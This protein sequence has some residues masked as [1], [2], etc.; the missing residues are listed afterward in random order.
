MKRRTRTLLA[1][2]L[3]LAAVAGNA[4]TLLVVRKTDNAVDFIDP[5]S[6][7]RLDT[8]PLGLAPHEISVSPD[9][10]Y[11]AVSNYGTRESPGSTVSVLD[12]ER[13]LELRRIDLSP[14]TR[15]H[16]LA[17]FAP[18]R[19][20]VTTEGSRAL[21]IVDPLGGQTVQ[22]IDTGQDISHMVAVTPDGSTA[23]VANIGSGSTTAIDLRTGKRLAQLATGKGSEGLAV[24]A[25]GRELWVGA[26]AEGQLAII[27]IRSLEIVARLAVPGLPIRI[28]ATPDGDTVLVTCAGFSE[29][30]AYDAASR[31]ERARRPIDVPLAPGADERPFARLAPGSALPVGLILSSSGRSVFVAATMADKVIELDLPLLEAR[32]VIDV[33]G[34][35][36]GMGTTTTMPRAP[37]HACAPLP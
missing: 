24:V 30:V 33:G 36:D 4:E 17:W 14:H 35:P 7:L 6:G 9:G 28:V 19:L 15:P 8:V 20:A 25:G 2:G 18:N 5:G 1:I 3:L 37:C 31:E 29:I 21:L 27:D 16:G 11:A 26:R 13:A 23:F 32:R 34:E 12:L 10:R 22:A